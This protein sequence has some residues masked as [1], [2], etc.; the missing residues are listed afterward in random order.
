MVVVDMT[1][2][3]R[4]T[5][6]KCRGGGI[7][8]QTDEYIGRFQN[9]VDFIKSSEEKVDGL[10]ILVGY[11]TDGADTSD[12]KISNSDFLELFS[13]DAEIKKQV[14]GGNSTYISSKQCLLRCT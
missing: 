7:L 8:T 12:N 13:S 4:F 1:T 6:K 14:Q 9:S 5:R 10:G 2:V 11:I 3:P